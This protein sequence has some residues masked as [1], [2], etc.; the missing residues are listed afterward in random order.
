MSPQLGNAQKAFIEF[1]GDM[2]GS[3]G[4][5]RTLAEIYALL[6]CSPEP[7]D[8][9]EIMEALQISR[10]NANMNIRKLLDWKLVDKVNDIRSRRTRFTAEK[11]VLELTIK[12]I[13]AREERELVPVH[14]KLE[15]IIEQ[16]RTETGELS[17]ADNYF[18]R[19]MEEMSR[20]CLQM[21]GWL[22]R[23]LPLMRNRSAE[24]IE[25]L[26]EALQKMESADSGKTNR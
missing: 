3:W 25:K 8:T 22:S 12:L 11:D 21:E 9:E 13:D 15:T 26:I 10:G 20:F 17:E 24:E 23:L 14:R 18:V 1:W 19:R 2:A 6:Y 7:F 16:F 5:N 4:S